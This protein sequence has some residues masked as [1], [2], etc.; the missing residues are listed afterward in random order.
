MGHRRVTDPDYPIGSLAPRINIVCANHNI[1]C[2]VN[3][4]SM[5]EFNFNRHLEIVIVNFSIRSV[6]LIILHSIR[7]MHFI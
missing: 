7:S 4:E 3:T 6:K 5:K 1:F 2:V